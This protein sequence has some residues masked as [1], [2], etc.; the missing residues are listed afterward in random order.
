M[1]ASL[2]CDTCPG[3][4]IY[5]Y[6]CLLFCCVLSVLIGW[7]INIDVLFSAVCFLSWMVDQLIL[8]FGFLLCVTCRGLLINWYWGLLFCCVLPVLHGW[9]IN[10]GVCFSDGCYLSWMVNQLLLM[11][12]FLLN[13]TCPGLLIDWYWWLL[14]CS[15]LPVLQGWPL[16]EISEVLQGD[17]NLCWLGSPTP[18]NVITKTPYVIIYPML[19]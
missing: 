4:L 14:L 2:L 13:A 11:F 3:W 6:W 7:Y 19:T 1:S 9:S 17:I 18:L 12:A 15:V 16:S 10:I 5:W 8:M